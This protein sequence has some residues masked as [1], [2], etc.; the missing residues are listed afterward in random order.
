MNLAQR[1]KRLITAAVSVIGVVLLLQVIIFPFME[2][3]ERSLRKIE[4]KQDALQEMVSLSAEYSRFTKDALGARERLAGR[5]KNFTLF[6]FLEK[7]AGST[8]I[9]T[10]IKYMKPS[11]SS[12]KGPFTESLVEMKLE[13]VSLEQ[14]AGYLQR[15][16]SPK[17]VVSVRRISIQ[18]NKADTGFLDAV[19]QVLTFVEP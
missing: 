13:R 4:A 2:R 1:E 16:E 12:G 8:N 14:L 18:S 7:A 9:K 11:E 10:H 17:D 15:I 19:I 6:S 5:Q 3:R